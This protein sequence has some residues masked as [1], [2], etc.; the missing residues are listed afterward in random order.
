[1]NKSRWRYRLKETLSAA[2]ITQAELAKELGITQGAV[3]SILN[4]NTDPKL[5][6]FYA[7]CTA[8]SLSADWVLFGEVN[9]Q[10]SKKLSKKA[11]N[12]ALRWQ[13]LPLNYRSDIER[14]VEVLSIEK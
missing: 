6:T 11:L 2:N 5:E 7:I 8:L 1:M 13:Q 3:S 4:G 10:P 9:I 12:L 14:A